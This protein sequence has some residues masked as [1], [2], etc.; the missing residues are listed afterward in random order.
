MLLLADLL[1]LLFLPPA[2][3]RQPLIFL[4]LGGQATLPL[5]KIPAAGHGLLFSDHRAYCSIFLALVD[6]PRS[7]GPKWLDTPLIRPGKL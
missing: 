1:L 4:V 7:G 5:G 3:S 2:F 6:S